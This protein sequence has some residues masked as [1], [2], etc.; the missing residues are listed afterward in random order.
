VL[1]SAAGAVVLALGL[2]ACGMNVNAAGNFKPRH[3]G[4]LTVATG[5]IPLAGMWTG[6]AKHPTGG[7]EYE[8]AKA[9]AKRFGLGR[10]D[11]VVIP[12]NR[13]VRGD[14]G[15]ADLVL[16]DMT[17]TSQ[18][19]QYLDFTD[20]YLAATP[21]VVVRSG[22][23]VPD[24]KTAQGLSWAVG[25]STTL[26]DFLED[27]IHPSGAVV[28]TSS[29]AQTVAAIQDGR[30]D[31]GLVDLPV[32]AAVARESGGKLSVAGQFEAN[33]DV[34]AALP[35]KSANVDPVSSALRA[36]IADGTV[37]SLAHHWLGLT[38]KGTVAVHVPLIRTE[39]T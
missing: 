20:P 30:V 2:A 29:L 12:F 3:P 17:A 37:A 18:R 23:D 5:E 6:T 19:A 15:R 27:T 24:L 10:V 1:R 8:L 7:F 16:S 31:A 4:A 11:V 36:L 39:S 26:H 25:E 14:M 32:A 28:L 22:R 38:V 13:L 9:L 21:A 34:S 35:N 33:D